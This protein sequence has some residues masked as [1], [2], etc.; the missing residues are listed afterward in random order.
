MYKY[1]NFNLG[2]GKLFIEDKWADLKLGAGITK[3]MLYLT[4]NEKGNLIVKIIGTEDEVEMATM[5]DYFFSQNNEIYFQDGTSLKIGD[6]KE[7]VLPNLSTSGNDKFKYPYVFG[8]LNINTGKGNDV[9]EGTWM[10][11]IISG[12]D[13]D[14]IIITQSGKDII[15]S[16]KGNDVIQGTEYDWEIQT[17]N[18]NVGDGNDTIID[19]GFILNFGEGIVK[20][21]LIFE[22]SEGKLV[23]KFKNNPNDS[24]TVNTIAE[25]SGTRNIGYCSINFSNGEVMSSTEINSLVAITSDNDDVIILDSYL[26]EADQDVLWDF[27]KPGEFAFKLDGKG[28]N[29]II[30][31]TYANEYLLGGDGNDYLSGGDGCDTLA[32]GEGN[33]ILVGGSGDDIYEFNL[34]D[35]NDTIKEIDNYFMPFAQEN[36]RL[37]EDRIVF[38][39]GIKLE[40]LEISLDYKRR[41]VIGI[42]GTSDTLTVEGFNYLSYIQF[43]DTQ[44]IIF[45]NELIQ[46]L[47]SSISVTGGDDIV[48][49]ISAPLNISTGDGNDLITAGDFLNEI[50]AGEGNDIIY[51][52]GQYSNFKGGK[53]ND[54][55]YADGGVFHFNIGDGKDIIYLNDIS[56]LNP[57][58]YGFDAEDNISI[59]YTGISFGEG[60]SYEDLEI[61]YSSTGRIIKIK[62]T[63]DSIE[64]IGNIQTPINLQF[65]NSEETIFISGTES[66]TSELINSAFVSNDWQGNREG[67]NIN[68]N[69]QYSISEINFEISGTDL[70]ISNKDKSSYVKIENYVKDCVLTLN[71]IYTFNYEELLKNTGDVEKNQ[72]IDTA[73]DSTILGTVNNDFIFGKD[74]ND[75]ISSFEGNDYINYGSGNNKVYG[76]FGDD[77]IYSTETANDSLNLIYGEEGN[78]II[79][80]SSG[81]NY[82]NGGLGDDTLIANGEGSN[83]F[84]YNIG[85]GKDTIISNTQGENY[86]YLLRDLT[87]DNVYFSKENNNLVIYTSNSEDKITLENYYNEKKVKT[88]D[89]FFS[90]LNGNK[91]NFNLNRVIF[92]TTGDA[93][94]GYEFD[95]LEEGHLW[96]DTITATNLND[97]INGLTGED[98]IFGEGGNDIIHGNEHNDKLYGGLGNDQLFGDEGD[99]YLYGEEGNDYL[100]GGIGNDILNGGE[101]DDIL[102]GGEGINTYNFNLGDGNDIIKVADGAKDTLSFLRGITKDEV[103]YSKSGDN[104]TISTKADKITVE[105][106][107]KGN[108]LEQITFADGNRITTSEIDDILAKLTQNIAGFTSGNSVTSNNIF[109]NKEQKTEILMSSY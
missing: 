70:F 2:D 37:D 105:N 1:Y 35:G 7:M 80:T 84:V 67:N 79:S 60:I 89:P 66:I 77:Y 94:L 104:L 106:W 71:E 40:D 45:F 30:E 49:L 13:G 75:T 39:N 36:Y 103:T 22:K 52:D 33:D 91:S 53:G 108:K 54:T 101:G 10:D 58:I 38:G 62:G 43:K 19:N 12:G 31:G 63:D 16:G 69:T 78:D 15:T 34:G 83:T 11:D 76:G 102:L 100:S 64:I 72:I 97:V 73:I 51:S 29:D 44:D 27:K 24:I 95:N 21:D 81:E 6:I 92:G 98:Y 9:I 47:S 68:V 107:A 56:Y 88:E 90:E 14:D 86:L 87:R 82:I 48:T 74:G 18:F 93:I 96:S 59:P 3:E 8:S 5:G 61:D 109:G 50:D 65:I 99:D 41:I 23:I 42:K 57:F 32:G 4:L 25:Y 46:N 85:D 20:E 26:N 17:I 28:G 55:F